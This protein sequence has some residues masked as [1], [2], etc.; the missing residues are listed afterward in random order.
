MSNAAC[1]LVSCGTAEGPGAG[2]VLNESVFSAAELTG[3]PSYVTILDVVNHW[4]VHP[5]WKRLRCETTES[6][7]VL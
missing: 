6:P 5:G 1:K 2:V 7:V 3:G 4:T